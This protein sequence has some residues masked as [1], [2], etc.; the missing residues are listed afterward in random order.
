MLHYEGQPSTKGGSSRFP[1]RMLAAE[2]LTS[3]WLQLGWCR[4]Y[5]LLVAVRM[6]AGQSI[7]RL[8]VLPHQRQTEDAGKKQRQRG[9]LWDDDLRERLINERQGDSPDWRV[10]IHSGQA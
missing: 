8:T 4:S 2:Y 9:R 6:I 10:L 1:G 3:A 7:L 5:R